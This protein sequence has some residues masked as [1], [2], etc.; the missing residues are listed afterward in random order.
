MAIIKSG[1]FEIQKF[2]SEMGLAEIHI[3]IGK[4]SLAEV[5]MTA[6]TSF[7]E[8]YIAVPEVS[9][10]EVYVTVETGTREVD[11]TVPETRQ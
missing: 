9:L 1:R 4:A 2:A 8:V 3:T 6:E 11:A 5:Y 10:R 7:I